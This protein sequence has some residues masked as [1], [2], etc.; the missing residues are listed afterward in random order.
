V[1]PEADGDAIDL[2][3]LQRRF[4]S[5]PLVHLFHCAFVS[6]LSIIINSLLPLSKLL[7]P[8]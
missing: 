7:T 5:L 8:Y 1:F 6:L 2:G 3:S 4:D